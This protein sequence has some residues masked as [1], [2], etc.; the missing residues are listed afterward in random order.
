MKNKNDE[1]IIKNK[2]SKMMIIISIIIICLVALA[3]FIML[4]SNENKEKLAKYNKEIKKIQI[5]NSKSI[6][7]F[8]DT[9]EYKTKWTYE[10]LLNN[11][12]DESKLSDNTK[13]KILV[14]D[15]EFNNSSILEFDTVGNYEI[16]IYLT[17]EYRYKITKEIIENIEVKKE[18]ILNVEDTIY[19]VIEGVSNKT[20]TVGDTIDL[21]NGISATDEIEGK[22]AL[23]IEG[24]IDTNKV[25]TY[26]IKVFATDVNGNRTDKEFTVTV[27]EK[28]TTNSGSSN[29]K[30]TTTKKI[31][32]KASSSGS[33]SSTCIYTKTLGKRGYNRNDKDACEK[34]KQAS[35]IAKQIANSILAKGYKTDLEKV[36]SA[37]QEVASYYVRENHTE[38]GLDYRTPYGLFVLHTAS[39]AGCTRALIQVLEYMG[40]TNITHANPNS[41]THQWV[42]LTMDG[43]VGYADGQVGW[44][45]YGCHPSDDNC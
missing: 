7:D 31:T 10:E 41:W 28:T 12:V 30:T 39:C 16:V 5:Q 34:D 24:E 27:K 8:N 37:A 1:T 22:L 23:Q 36:S 43:Q 33:S 14:N 19:P 44:A 20:I 25:G 9:I 11:L 38:S 32:T 26:T 13:I 35:A 18:V 15:E 45:G 2:H 21:L 42:K 40:F 4:I 29:S 6:I 3:F 17:K